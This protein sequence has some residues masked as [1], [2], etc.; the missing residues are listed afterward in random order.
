[1][2]IFNYVVGQLATNTDTRID[3]TDN[4]LKRVD[5]TEFGKDWS[6]LTGGGYLETLKNSISIFRRVWCTWVTHVWHF[7]GTSDQTALTEEI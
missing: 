1:M 5:E 2:A 4:Q 6:K 7:P 3:E